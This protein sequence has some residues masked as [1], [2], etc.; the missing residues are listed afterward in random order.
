MPWSFSD[1]RLE[2]TVVRQNEQVSYFFGDPETRDAC[3]EDPE[4][5]TTELYLST[6]AFSIENERGAWRERPRFWVNEWGPSE[7]IV[8]DGEGEYEGLVAVL[9]TEDLHKDFWGA[10]IDARLLPPP[11]ENASTK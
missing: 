9:Y 7:G 6:V 5:E 4:C 3:N 11:P 1:P 2:G 8:L 10:I